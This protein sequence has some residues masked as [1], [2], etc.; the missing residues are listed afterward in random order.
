MESPAQRRY[1]LADSHAE[2]EERSGANGV[3]QG[4]AALL[5]RT[6]REGTVVHESW[7]H[8]NRYERGGRRDNTLDWL[9]AC[10]CQAVHERCKGRCVIRGNRPSRRDARH[11]SPRD[12]SL[13]ARPKPSCVSTSPLENVRSHLGSN[14]RLVYT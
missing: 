5:I 11:H 10:G 6:V 14:P 12:D 8:S 13:L 2:I 3:E 9:L 4:S 1:P 7:L